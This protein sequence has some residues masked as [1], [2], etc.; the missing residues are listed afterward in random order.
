MNAHINSKI[1]KIYDAPDVGDLRCI[2]QSDGV[3]F[4]THYLEGQEDETAI[5]VGVELRIAN[6]DGNVTLVTRRVATSPEGMSRGSATMLLTPDAARDLVA[7]LNAL[8]SKLIQ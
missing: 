7:S 2:E 8:I 4:M 1:H 5:S 6:K 3:S